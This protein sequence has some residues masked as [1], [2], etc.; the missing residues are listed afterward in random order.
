MLTWNEFENHYQLRY[1]LCMTLDQAPLAQPV[2]VQE[3]GGERAFRRRIMELG[4]IPGTVA[5]VLRVAP[6]GDPIEIESRGSNLSI[7]RKEANNILVAPKSA[8]TRTAR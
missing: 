6:L 3:V 5:R 7:R 4:L 2:V 1:K 8:Q